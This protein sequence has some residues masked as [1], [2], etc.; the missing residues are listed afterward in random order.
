MRDDRPA[1]ASG[2]APPHGVRDG[3]GSLSGR[4]SRTGGLPH[5]TTP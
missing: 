4:R 2:Q 1:G 3:A 5:L